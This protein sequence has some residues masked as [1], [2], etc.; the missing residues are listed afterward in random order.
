MK[1]LIRLILVASF[2]LALNAAKSIDLNDSLGGVPLEVATG[3][4]APA[5]GSSSW[6][7]IPADGVDI[8][9]VDG[10]NK[11]WLRVKN[12][13]SAEGW[14]VYG[15]VHAGDTVAVRNSIDATTYRIGFFSGPGENAL[16]SM[17]GWG[18]RI[19][20]GRNRTRI[21]P[22]V[23]D[24]PRVPAPKIDITIGG[25]GGSGGGGSAAAPV[26]SGLE[27]DPVRNSSDPQEAFCHSPV[28]AFNRE[29]Y[30]VTVRWSEKYDAAGAPGCSGQGIATRSE[31]LDAGATLRVFC[32][33]V[34]SPSS[35]CRITR[36]ASEV[37]SVRR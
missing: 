11:F 36:S 12:G 28:R 9:T 15:P 13:K 5:P 37:T 14:T 26:K 27:P 18:P 1:S 8:D 29:S 7:S 32:S 31:P 19:T 33:V 35:T 25:G 6:H 16:D 4:S 20:L 30:P 10:V 2:A 34:V 17:K 24:T 22:V 23:F 3:N 21:G